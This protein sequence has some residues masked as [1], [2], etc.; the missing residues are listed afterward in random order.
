MRVVRVQTLPPPSPPPPPLLRTHCCAMPCAL[1]RQRAAWLQPPLQAGV[2]GILGGRSVQAGAAPGRRAMGTVQPGGTGTC[3]HA[4]LLGAPPTQST[5]P[6]PT[7]RHW[8][9]LSASRAAATTHLG[10]FSVVSFS[11]SQVEPWNLH[12]EGGGGA[13]VPPLRHFQRCALGGRSCMLPPPPSGSCGAAN[14][15]Q[16]GKDELHAGL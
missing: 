3:Q 5:P 14:T 12:G 9:H 15:E 11:V 13:T 10:Y 8:P 6:H 16:A 1:G 2:G 7:P 4:A